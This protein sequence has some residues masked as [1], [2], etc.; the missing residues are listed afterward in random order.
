MNQTQPTSTH[1]V[2]PS[3]RPGD[4]P[5]LLLLQPVLPGPGSTVNVATRYEDEIEVKKGK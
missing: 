1:P 4:A 3:C 5:G 2:I